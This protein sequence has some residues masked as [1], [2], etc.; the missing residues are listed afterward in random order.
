[1]LEERV[2]VGS[3]S[4]SLRLLLDIITKILFEWLAFAQ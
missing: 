4:L 1:M 3:G 2:T